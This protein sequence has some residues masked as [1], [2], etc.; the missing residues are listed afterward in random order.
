[1]SVAN[2]H[3]LRALKFRDPGS[4]G[5]FDLT[6]LENLSADR[7]FREI[8][9]S[10]AG[11]IAPCFKGLSGTDPSISF[12]STQ[13]L[14][15]L[16][17]FRNSDAS[18]Q[19]VITD[20]SAGNVDLVYGAGAPNSTRDADAAA[21]HIIGTLANNAAIYWNSLT[22]RQDE[23]ASISAIIKTSGTAAGVDA[24]SYSLSALAGGN[25][26]PYACSDLFTLSKVFYN[27]TQISGVTSVNW[28]NNVNEINFRSDGDSS[29]CYFGIQDMAPQVTVTTS[30]NNEQLTGGI[31]GSGHDG[32]T[33]NLLVVYLKKFSRTNFFVD[34]SLTQHIRLTAQSGLK[35]VPTLSGDPAETTLQF[36]LEKDSA[37]F[38]FDIETGVAIP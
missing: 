13:L 16:N 1:M 30:N 3:H 21:S 8:S 23:K 9:Q 20:L 31:G 5:A 22:A 12:D 38:V 18:N 37:G 10:S 17:M 34:E 7:N 24:L 29:T 35:T 26:T 27:G 11:D 14:S 2:L 4:S 36:M 32:V 6:H 19:R 33:T 28:Q 25:A 15:L